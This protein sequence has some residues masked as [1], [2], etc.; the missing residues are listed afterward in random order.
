MINGYL[1]CHKTVGGHLAR[2]RAHC[3][4]R[5]SPEPTDAA[6]ECPGRRPPIRGGQDNQRSTMGMVLSMA[7]LD[8]Q[9]LAALQIVGQGVEGYEAAEL[10][11]DIDRWNFGQNIP[12][13]KLRQYS[14]N[15]QGG[16]WGGT[17][18]AKSNVPWWQQAAGLG[19]TAAGIY[20]MFPSGGSGG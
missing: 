8:Y 7:S 9:D 12:D 5:A 13:E 15:I 4:N 6:D 16:N 10:Q 14:T 20:G 2:K 18:Q 3:D 19:L 17:T 1:S 11:D